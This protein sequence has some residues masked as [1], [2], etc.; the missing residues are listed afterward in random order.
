MQ[1][2][3]DTTESFGHNSAA[4]DDPAAH[5]IVAHPKATMRFLLD[6]LFSLEQL[7]LPIVRAG[8]P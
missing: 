1:A 7:H 8:N 5:A 3:P 4:I 6:M 2:V